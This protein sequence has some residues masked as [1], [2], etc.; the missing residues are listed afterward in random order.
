MLRDYPAVAPGMYDRLLMYDRLFYVG[1]NSCSR[2][3]PPEGS[4][5]KLRV[6]A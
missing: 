2:G 5:G 1:T 3:S 6:A 4:S